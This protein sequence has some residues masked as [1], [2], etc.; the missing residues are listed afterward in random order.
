MCVVTLNC[1]IGSTWMSLPATTSRVCSCRCP[2]FL[3]TSRSASTSPRT[4]TRASSSRPTASSQR[5]ASRWSRWRLASGVWRLELP[6][7]RPRS[8]L[9]LGLDDVPPGPRA[10][11]C[12]DPRHPTDRDADRAAPRRVLHRRLLLPGAAPPRARDHLR[13]WLE[14]AGVRP[15]MGAWVTRSGGGAP[16]QRRDRPHRSRACW[17]PR[18]QRR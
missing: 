9:G 4:A 3:L 1:A 14:G 18:R 8:W 5:S 7:R 13:E 6:A 16:C 11:G 10:A 15:L 17:R 12:G 2:G